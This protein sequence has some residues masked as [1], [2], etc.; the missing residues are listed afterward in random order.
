MARGWSTDESRSSVRS[1]AREM[2]ALRWAD[3]CFGF[4]RR[5]RSLESVRVFEVSYERSS[6]VQCTKSGTGS[7]ICDENK[8]WSQAKGKRIGKQSWETGYW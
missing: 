3:V 8:S 4:R 2:S 7:I 5:R 6:T 1:G